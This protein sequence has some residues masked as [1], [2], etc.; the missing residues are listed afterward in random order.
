MK[1]IHSGLNFQLEILGPA[2]VKQQRQEITDAV[3]GQLVKSKTVIA[4][5]PVSILP[6]VIELSYYGNTLLSHYVMDSV[7]V[8][9]LYA[10]LR[11][12]TKNPETAKNDD[13]CVSHSSLVD[14]ARIIC[15]IL[16]YE[17]IFCRPCQELDQVIAGA[18]DNLISL[19]IIYGNEVWTTKTYDWLLRLR[20][21]LI[22]DYNVL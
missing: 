10:A 19:G 9:A 15:D 20:F 17:F 7:M 18:I 2:L 8:T 13:L 22:D 1:F 3:D 11:S 14:N 21:T 4:I 12:Q 6:N 5:R 16:K